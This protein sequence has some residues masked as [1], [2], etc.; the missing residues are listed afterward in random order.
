MVWWVDCCGLLVVVMGGLEVLEFWMER[1]AMV[2][3]VVLCRRG[4]ILR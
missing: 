3:V 1:M 2:S 4:R